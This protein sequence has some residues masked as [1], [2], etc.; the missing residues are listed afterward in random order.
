MVSN[1]VTLNK[2]ATAVVPGYE[3]VSKALISIYDYIP[4]AAVG[5]TTVTSSLKL[6]YTSSSSVMHLNSELLIRSSIHR[7]F[8]KFPPISQ[9]FT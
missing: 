2:L 8:S 7:Y 5:R 4:R 1:M 9:L 3:V 6:M